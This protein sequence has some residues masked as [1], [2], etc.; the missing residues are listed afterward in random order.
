[1]TVI[2]LDRLDTHPLISD[3]IR[4]NDKNNFFNQIG[5]LM[6]KI[7]TFGISRKVCILFITSVLLLLACIVGAGLSNRQRG[8]KTSQGKARN[9]ILNRRNLRDTGRIQRQ[10]IACSVMEEKRRC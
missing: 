7:F 5:D 1:M 4:Y 6:K 10:R 8:D 2:C 3:C 9:L